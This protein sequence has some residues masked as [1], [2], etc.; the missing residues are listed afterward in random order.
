MGEGD[1]LSPIQKVL[2]NHGNGKGTFQI[3]KTV[4]TIRAVD[5]VK[6]GRGY[7][8]LAIFVLLLVKLKY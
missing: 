2:K 4:G 5:A 8:I 1:L 3:L 6:N 7:D